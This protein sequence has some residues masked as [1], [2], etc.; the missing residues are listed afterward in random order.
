MLILI[1]LLSKAQDQIKLLNWVIII[2]RKD[3]NL[4]AALYGQLH[5]CLIDYDLEAEKKIKV[6]GVSVDFLR[7]QKLLQT[8]SKNKSISQR[9]PKLRNYVMRSM[10]RAQR[11][12]IIREFDI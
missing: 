6:C 1:A 2:C 11:N 7:F 8:R 9:R 12:I 4:F 5:M 3:L 10:C